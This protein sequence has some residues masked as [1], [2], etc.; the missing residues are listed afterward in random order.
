[1]DMTR[2]KDGLGI[3]GKAVSRRSPEILTAL[4]I[5]GFITTTVLACRVTSRAVDIHEHYEWEREKG[6]ITE[7]DSRIEQAKA[8]LPLYAPAAI[9]GGLSIVCILGAHRIQTSRTAAIATAYSLTERTLK[10]YQDKVIEKLG[11]DG[12]KDLMQLVSDKLADEDV[13]FDGGYSYEPD[14]SGK[15][16]CYDRVTGRYFRSNPEAIRE[17]ESQVNKR[18]IDEVIVPLSEFYFY[19]GIDDKGFI[20]DALGWDL[21]R[22]KLDVYFT[23]MLDDEKRPCLVLNYNVGIVDRRIFDKR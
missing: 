21:A 6:N 5:S 2:V 8:I 1:M 3:I 23:S 11:E 9:S 12:H 22:D 20:C 16:L 10:T 17:A 4:G 13:P 14:A 19:L 7:R 15:T 18:L